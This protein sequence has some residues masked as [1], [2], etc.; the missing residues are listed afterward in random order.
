MASASS[1]TTMTASPKAQPTVA[2]IGCGPAGMFFMH[3]NATRR[4]TMEQDGD[5]EGLQRLPASITCYERSSGPG[6]VWK[7]ERC[8]DGG[9]E[10]PIAGGGGGSMHTTGTF[11]SDGEE[12]KDNDGD[13]EGSLLK[14]AT[15]DTVDTDATA[16][17]QDISGNMYEALW[18]NGAKERIEF[19]DYTYEDHF[20]KDT[21]L[22]TYMP[23]QPLLEYFVSRVTR[24]N[25]NFFDDVRFETTV[26]NVTYDEAT[27]KFAVTAQNNLTGEEDTAHYDKCVWAAGENGKPNIPR[28][29]N[30]LLHDDG[31][32]GKT[33]HSSQVGAIAF[34][35]IV[36]DR[37]VLLVGDSFSSEDLALVAIKAGAAKVYIVSRSGDG[38][39][40]YISAWPQ[41]KVEIIGGMK[42]TDVIQN[43]NGIRFQEMEYDT[44][45]WEFRL[46]EEGETRDVEDLSLVIYCTGYKSN[47]QM[48][49]N[50]LKKPYMK[51]ESFDMPKGW[52][53]KPNAFSEDLGDVPPYSPIEPIE[54]SSTVYMGI[55]RGLL[56]SNPNMMYIEQFSSAPLFEIDVYAWLCLAYITGDAEIPSYEE[57]E[58]R[59]A[60][61]LIDSMSVHNL[62]YEID[63][64]YYKALSEIDE[65]HWSNDCLDPRV[66][67]IDDEEQA[68]HLRVLAQ[69]MRDAK[70]PDDIGTY[71]KLNTKGEALVKIETA[72]WRHRISLPSEGPEAE[73]MTFRD[74]DP[75]ELASIHT[76]AKAVPLKK[77]WID[78]DNH[79]YDELLGKG[80]AS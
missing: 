13:G 2:V 67:A 58:R 35:T 66:M 51:P 39:V 33:I 3:A 36:R 21:D 23:R 73:W 68:F 60:Q 44:D 20:G 15:I 75:T 34:D 56:M 50:S 77:R 79:D 16:P 22:P 74:G 70:Y 65:S 25:P 24:N 19:C 41:D 30:E 6:G 71:E 52:K 37:N 64:N 27:A 7:A 10:Q 62:R 59:N 31:F 76:G 47:L 78:L 80:S 32:R 8:H 14:S 55:Y 69:N 29:M 42:A 1:T 61:V 17:T 18:T 54:G 28:E 40:N 5:S 12:K 53:M 48:I 46:A 9:D 26:I 11:D 49:D 4:R 57:M 43:G 72:S 38:V 63:G 45:E